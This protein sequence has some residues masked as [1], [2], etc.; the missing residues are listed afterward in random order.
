MSYQV[1]RSQ[2]LRPQ[3]RWDRNTRPPVPKPPAGSCDCQFHIFS[4][5]SLYPIRSFSAAE[6][7]PDATFRDIRRVHGVLG[8]DRGVIVHS[9]RY[10]TDHRPLLDALRSL[11]AEERKNYRATCIINDSVSDAEMELLNSLGVRG[12][13]FN[14]GH[15][16]AES[17]DRDAVRRSMAR[18]REIGWHARLH[19]SGSD[20]V[21]WGD[22]LLSI[23]DM[24]MV[25]DHM[26]HLEYELGLSQPALLWITERLATD[27]NWWLMLSNG[28]RD[29]VMEVGWDDAIPFAQ[30]FIT[31]AP[32][33]TIWGTDWPHAGWRRTRMMNDAELLELMYRYVDHD[34]ALLQKILV[35]NPARLHGFEN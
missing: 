29:S 14:I 7:P 3:G 2:D 30:A 6:E 5:P 32:D 24:P 27:E 10:G 12:A 8:I 23:R 26:G 17:I 28:N 20:I 21:E 33:R 35:D 15:R 22:F 9:Q 16:W 34:A 19:V 18:V 31:A 4:D 25:I 11:T 13:R 1:H